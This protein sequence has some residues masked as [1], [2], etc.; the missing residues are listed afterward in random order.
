MVDPAAKVS[1]GVYSLQCLSIQWEAPRAFKRG[2]AV[3]V[4][5]NVYAKAFI[6]L[7][8]INPHLNI[9]WSNIYIYS[10]LFDICFSTC[11]YVPKQ[12]SIL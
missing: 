1:Q 6:F 10:I 2:H 11:G 8:P 7:K 4:A 9:V 5:L 3:Q 12:R